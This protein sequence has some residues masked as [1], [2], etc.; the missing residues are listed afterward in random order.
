M[1]V[2]CSDKTGTITEGRIE[3]V[4]AVD[5]KGETSAK[6]SLCAYLNAANETGFI[7][8]ID[9]ALRAQ[10]PPDC[11]GWTKLDE[12]PYD[13]VRK[14]VFQQDKIGRFARDIEHRKLEPHAPLY[15]VAEEKMRAS[16]AAGSLA[17][18][19]L[20]HPV[21]VA[22]GWEAW[23]NEHLPIERPRRWP[24]LGVFFGQLVDEGHSLG[25]HWLVQTKLPRTRKS[26]A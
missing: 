23:Q 22:G 1:N 17:G 6:V 16:L 13:F 4:A 25:P 5:A 10:P 12:L 7:N 18:A 15:L 20:E 9:E 19:G 26:P 14:R 21:V 11:A 2:L 8:P 3:I 24:S